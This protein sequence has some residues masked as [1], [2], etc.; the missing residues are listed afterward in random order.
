MVE[1]N[2][3][4]KL[5]ELLTKKKKER[6][7][8]ISVADM[9][10]ITN[11]VVDRELKRL[12]REIE[13]KVEKWLNGLINTMIQEK[14]TGEKGEDG[15]GG[16]DGKDGKDGM[17]GKDGRDG[18]DGK[19]GHNGKDG[20]DG[21]KGKDGM[22]PVA[23]V[24]YMTNDESKVMIRQAAQI[25]LADKRGK[26]GSPDT[27]DEVVEKIN[28]SKKQIEPSQIRGLEKLVRGITVKSGGGGMGQPIPFSFTGDASTTSFTLSSKVA[29]NGLAI[30][31]YYQGMWL[32][33]TVHFNVV[34][35]SFN[36]T[37]T[38]ENNAIIEGFYFR[39]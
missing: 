6:D 19:D 26:D 11:A 18:K 1:N 27:P 24:D 16:I 22:T 13:D 21:K 2:M 17:D 35:K 3:A 39:T 25:I 10:E 12:Q 15:R 7:G 14:F 33:P 23:G 32:Q 31:A 20:K 37:F 38:P 29:A 28:E 4:N 30:W 36:T 34:D 5:K 9:E 8:G